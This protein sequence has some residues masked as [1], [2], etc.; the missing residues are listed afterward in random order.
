MLLTFRLATSLCLSAHPPKEEEQEE[1]KEEEE[2]ED[3]ETLVT[4][5]SGRN[6]TETLRGTFR[7][8]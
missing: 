6:G 2:E 8:A 7:S 3:E 4:G 5:G 1:E